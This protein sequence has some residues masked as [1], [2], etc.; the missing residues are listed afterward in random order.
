MF[1]VKH[2]GRIENLIYTEKQS[3]YNERIEV[4]KNVEI[5]DGRGVSEQ[6]QREYL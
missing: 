6:S 1:H 4:N 3:L 5:K 2:L